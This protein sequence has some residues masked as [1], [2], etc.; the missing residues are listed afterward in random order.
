[1]QVLCH[2]QEWPVLGVAIEELA[3][4]AEHPIRADSYELATQ[5]L[6]LFRVAEPG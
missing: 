3:Q 6:A 5:A 1:M 4:L 2:Q